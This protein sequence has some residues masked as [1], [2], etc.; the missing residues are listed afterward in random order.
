M[1]ANS[2]M[3]LRMIEMHCII[4]RLYITNKYNRGC[5]KYVCWDEKTIKSELLLYNITVIKLETIT[6][7]MEK[8]PQEH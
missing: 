2:R 6:L 8:N 7:Q 5:M 3:Y 4:P 1:N